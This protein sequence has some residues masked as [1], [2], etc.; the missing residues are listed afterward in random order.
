MHISIVT[1][2]YNGSKETLELL[3]SLRE[4]ADQDF[5][6][7]VVDNGSEETDFANLQSLIHSTPPGG[8]YPQAVK[9]EENL[10]FSGGNNVG[11]RHAL[12]NGS[13]WV[14]LLNNDTW[15]EKDFMERLRAVLEGKRGIVGL[16]MDEGQRICYAGRV[17][18]LK[19]PRKFHINSLEEAKKNKNIYAI[20]GGMAIHCS[21][22]EK[23]GFLDE[24]YFLYFEDIDYSVR[25][26]IKN[27][28]IEITDKPVIHHAV[29]STT[30]KLGSSTIL[31]YH[32]RNALYFNLKNGPWYVKFLV[33]LWSWVIV[34]K[35][36]S[37]IVIGKNVKE[38]KAILAGVID[39]YKNKMGK[40]N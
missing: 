3:K 7:I 38:S 20:G 40:I 17:R 34:I 33:W 5:E 16:P 19:R 37:K 4:Q 30:K 26:R 15:V 31:R 13:D 8:V 27:V 29:S 6:I 1:L 36:L 2:N 39:F 9:N 18:W 23:I 21:V 32:Y 12:E 28:V 24:E 35:Q 14:V 10:G 22:F 25:A 11:I